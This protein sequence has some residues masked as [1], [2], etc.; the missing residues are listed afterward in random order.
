MKLYC[1][2][3]S[4]LGY[5][6]NLQLYSLRQAYKNWKYLN[7]NKGLSDSKILEICAFITATLGLSLSQLLGQNYPGP[8]EEKRNPSPKKLFDKVMPVYIGDAAVMKDLKNR[9]EE[10][11]DLYDASRHFGIDSDKYRHS[12]VGEINIQKVN[13]LLNTT[14]EIWD[15][16]ILSKKNERNSELFDYENIKELLE[17]LEEE[18][19]QEDIIE[20][21]EQENG[22]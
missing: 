16:I 3:D 13:E 19:F 9:F 20:T 17:E 2:S 1:H 4:A 10:L 15:L 12:Q 18:G 22:D 8:Y 7:E 21:F 11:I 5:A 14:F 6:T